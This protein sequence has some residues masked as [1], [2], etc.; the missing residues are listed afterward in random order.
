VAVKFPGEVSFIQ[1][2][3]PPRSVESSELGAAYRELT[4]P[5]RKKVTVEVDWTS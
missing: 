4:L 2:S 3:L 5:A 1:T